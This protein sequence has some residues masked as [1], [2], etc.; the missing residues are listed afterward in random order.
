MKLNNTVKKGLPLT[1]APART[2][3]KVIYHCIAREFLLVMQRPV[4]KQTGFSRTCERNRN[5]NIYSISSWIYENVLCA[6]DYL[7]RKCALL[8]LNVVRSN[9]PKSNE[10]ER[11]E[12]KKRVRKKNSIFMFL[13]LQL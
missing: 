8:V 3:R 1:S 13:Y 11:K 4:S 7:Y 9:G 6:F 10:Q 12:G 5:L 2:S